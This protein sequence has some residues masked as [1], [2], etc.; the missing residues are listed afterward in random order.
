M[1]HVALI[2]GINVGKA[3]R[4]AMAD[5]R[6]LVDGLGYGDVRTVLN[7]G[8]VVYDAGDVEPAESA[9]R[10][11]RAMSRELGVDA[12]VIALDA[13]TIATI[14]DE[15]PLLDVADNPSRLVVSVVSDPAALEDLAPLEQRDWSPG[16]LAVG[17]HA[18]YL[19]C[20]DGISNSDLVVEAG[21]V[22]GDRV[23]SRNWSTMS[24][25]DALANPE[26]A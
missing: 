8:N 2:R 23:T 6:A 16:A 18:A 14:V 10:L 26:R 3:K 25:L 9:A 4:V 1:I 22:L 11:E 5:L 13:A 20:P 24:K 7:S 21:R 19:W 15:C 17:P 12:R